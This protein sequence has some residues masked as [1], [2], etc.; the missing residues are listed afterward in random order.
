MSADPAAIP[1]PNPASDSFQ[2]IKID[3]WGPILLLL[4]LLV[5]AVI[6]WGRW[7][8]ILVDF[9]LQVYTP[10]QLSQGQVLYKDIIYIHGPLSAYIHSFVFMLFGP[11]ISVLAWFNIGLIIILTV[12]IH[13][14]FRNLFNPLTG[15][16][17]ALSFIVV[18][19]FGNYLQ[20]SNYNFVCAYEYTLPHGVFLSFVAIHQ[21]VNYLRTP[22]P[23]TLF[24][25]G[26]LSGLILLTK[27]EV[28][29]AEMVAIGT[30]LLLAF[31]THET[32]IKNNLQKILIFCSAFFIPSLVFIFYFSL[33]M[34]IEQALES[35]FTHL[36]YIF[37]SEIKTSPFYKGVTGTGFFWENLRN[38]FIIL[39]SYLFIYTV[40]TTLNKGIVR[41][42]GNTRA[43][44]WICFS[45]FLA[46][47]IIFKDFIFWMDLMRPLPLILIAYIGMLVYRWLYRSQTPQE[48]K[49]L[50]SILIVTLFSLILVVKIFLNV[51]VQHYG[52]ALTLP[53]FLI[54]AALLIYE[55]PLAFKT[56]QGSSLMPSAFGL[57]LLLA[58]TV[59]MGWASF[60]MYE[61]KD[62]PIGEGRDRVYD[63]S[64][65]RM[66][67]PAQPYVRGILFNYALEWIDQ[68][69]GPE[70]EFV[71]FPAANMLNYM[72]RR[73]SPIIAGIFNPGVLVLTGE[74]P[75]LNSLKKNAP[76]H[77]VLVDQEFPHF[78]ARF[79]GRDYARDTF[80]WIVQHY[81]VAQQIGARP[82]SHQGFGIQILK[83]KSL[84]TDQ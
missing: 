82:F 68:K 10:W 23:R 84:D 20:T 41:R 35:P 71:A 83:R 80:H 54:F 61:M 3:R 9:G 33:H 53:G 18:F 78:G 63:F 4:A 42:Y 17:A 25:I 55:L 1:D 34:P 72:S 50:I 73:R 77:I 30:G 58:H 22:L 12:I 46:L 81:Q 21:F 44:Y 79:F 56:I 49:R 51:H 76:D 40:L 52:F 38:L 43:I 65:H 36:T 16:L 67:T 59:M 37:N 26:L 75:L 47:L 74:G 11:G 28:F 19:A 70:E 24:W 39:G 2:N 64:P 60:N 66:G 48:K 7:M 15:F 27:P 5:M 62:F 8:D 29:L 13:Q 32:S 45:G 69:M 6:S 57:A 31:Q 14:L